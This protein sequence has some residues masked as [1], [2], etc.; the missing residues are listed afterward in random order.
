V[1]F[2]ESGPDAP[3]DEIAR[4]AGVGIATLFRRFPNRQALVRAALEQS[5]VEEVAPAVERA[6]DDD[7][8]LRA[9]ARVLE[10][11]MAATARERHT[12]AAAKNAGVV[13]GDVSAPYLE[14]L[15]LLTCRAQEAGL[16]RADLVPDDVPRI[17]AM[18]AGVIWTV[19]PESDGWRRYV[20]LMLDALS[21][22]GASPLPPAVAL[23]VPQPGT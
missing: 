16:V 8:P 12:L 15:T 6:F 14:S 17:M 3:L 5:S 2:A 7:D 4:R 20:T 22:A 23:R 21:P 18:L 1:V 19:D 9:L 10:A 13:I 11:A